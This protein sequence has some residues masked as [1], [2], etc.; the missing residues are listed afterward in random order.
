M[1][2]MRTQ[3]TS[4]E[5]RS[6]ALR[7]EERPCHVMNGGRDVEANTARILLHRKENVCSDRRNAPPTII[8]NSNLPQVPEVRPRAAGYDLRHGT[9]LDPLLSPSGNLLGRPGR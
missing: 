1:S 3:D 7:Y 5:V 9:E 2:V 6:D 4:E 8:L